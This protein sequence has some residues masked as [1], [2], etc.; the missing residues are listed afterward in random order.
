MFTEQSRQ[1]GRRA[2][3]LPFAPYLPLH[4]LHR[5]LQKMRQKESSSLKFSVNVRR[6][7]SSS[8]NPY[9]SQQNAFLSAEFVARRVE[10][11]CVIAWS[12]GA[13]QECVDVHR[14][15]TR[16][17][18]QPPQPSRDML[19]RSR[20]PAPVAPQIGRVWHYRA[21]TRLQQGLVYSHWRLS[22]QL[23]LARLLL[24]ETERRL[25][26][27]SR[28]RLYKATP[29]TTQPGTLTL[30]SLPSSGHMVKISSEDILGDIESCGS[31]KG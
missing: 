23:A 19:S 7:F 24:P 4:R 2:P 5:A 15:I 11:L 27:Y 9:R 21:A 18:F 17:P 16:R 8:G 3:G 10:K 12:N 6:R 22:F 20:L 26:R 14:P 31:S 1:I 29:W 30:Q 13:K 25:P 28:T